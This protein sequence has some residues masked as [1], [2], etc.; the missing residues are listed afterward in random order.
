[1]RNHG[2]SMYTLE[3]VIET[4]EVKLLWDFP[5]QT[6]NNLDHNR[7]DIVVVNKARRSYLLIGIACPF[8]TKRRRK[9]RLMSI[10]IC[11]EN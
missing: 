7:P 5:I 9:R 8:D 4:D 1:M 11:G 2:I 3:K 6:D 10:K